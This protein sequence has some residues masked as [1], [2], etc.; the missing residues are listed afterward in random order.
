[1]TESQVTN[2]LQLSFSRHTGGNVEVVAWHYEK[3]PISRM[4]T[5]I[6]LTA[7]V[8]GETIKARWANKEWLVQ[9]DADSFSHSTPIP[10]NSGYGCK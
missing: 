10:T 7:R 3:C 2:W 6:I 9:G 1:M 5:A 8:D 4:N